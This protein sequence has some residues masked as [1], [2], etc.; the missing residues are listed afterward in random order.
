MKGAR[1]LALGLCLAVTLAASS[2]RAQGDPRLRWRTVESPH[3]S[4]HF[5]NDLEPVA[6]RVAEVAEGAYE[7][8][9]GPMGLSLSQRTQVV[10]WDTTDDANG[11]ATSIPFNTVNL[12]V[13][14]PDDLSVLNQYDDWVS[15]LVTHELTHIL[16][17]D[18]ISGVAAVVNAIIGKQWSPNQ[19]QPRFIL[20]GLAVYEES[21][22]SRG[23]RLRSSMWDMQL[24]ADAL[25][26]N[27]ATLDQ[28][29]S[30]ANRW[31]HGN[32]WYLYGSSLFQYVAARFGPEVIPFLTR[33]YGSMAAPWQI[34]RAIRR[35]TGHSWEEIYDDWR[36]SLRARYALQR[37]AIA[38][39]GVEE[40]RRVTFQGETVRAPRY[41]PDGTLLYESSDGQSQSMI[42]ALSPAELARPRPRPAELAWQGS[43]SGFAVLDADHLLVSDI[44]PHRD[45]YLFHDLHRWSLSRDGGALSRAGSE[46][47]SDGWRAQQ[48]DAHPDGDTVAFTVNHRGTTELAEMSLTERRPRTIVRSRRYEQV[49][50]PRYSPDGAWIAFSR[51]SDGRRDLWRYRRADGHLEALTRDRALDLSPVYSPDG[52][53]LLWS[54]DRTGVMNLYAM[55]LATGER[56]Q[57]T[58][59]VMGA[60]QPAVSPDGRSIA[61]VGYTP[62]GWDLYVMP[63][64]P[65]RWRAPEAPL[66]D[67]FD[68]DGDTPPPIAHDHHA[69]E[70]S[71]QRGP[72]RPLALRVHDYDPWSTLRPRGWLLEYGV[73]GF[74]PQLAVRVLGADVVGRHS[75]NVRAGAGLVRGDPLFDATYVYRG[76]RP[77][78]RVRAYRTVDAGS[79]YSVSGANT[80][81]VAERV[82][83]ESELSVGFPG[84]FDAHSVS[85]SYEAQWVRALG[86][87]PLYRQGINPNDPPPTVPFE[88][89]VNGVRLSWGYSR[90]QRYAYSISAQ[91][92]FSAFA[93]VRVLDPAF[94]SA[95]GG[96]DLSA[97]VAG[98]LPMPWGTDRRRHVLAAR[99]GGGIAMTDAGERGAFALG[100]FPNL[101]VESL[102]D[103]FRLGV[104]N[105]GVALRGYPPLARVGS[106]FQLL[107]VEYRFP[108]WQT[109][110]GASSLPFFIQR[111]SGD[112]FM[113]A[114]NAGF[115][116]WR[117]D[118]LAVGAG[119]EVLVDLVLGYILPFTLRVGYARGFMEGGT[120]QTYGLLSAPF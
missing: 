100:G 23:G 85:L 109:R 69:G 66:E 96:I 98:Y 82:G 18:N 119:L 114:G 12:F 79:G 44:A 73:D 22:H 62:Y 120:D 25:G 65:S 24:R 9:R 3:F 105:G 58:N 94:G 14:A 118:T 117:L 15:T 4:V 41:L 20:E 40:G 8:L 68:R 112:V 92:G 5:Y 106:Q 47:L 83:G 71:S 78:L 74:G 35:A 13:T 17:T 107:N 29:A 102:I 67:F 88:G 50:A 2:A 39:R 46:R 103:A 84:V 81:W 110:R 32:I 56:W 116:P 21:L 80:Q 51:W 30:G 26:D 49:Y 90:V 93:S 1:R 61:Y 10:L 28:L 52:R 75:W 60:F 34:N 86:G 36:E 70:G 64:D 38:S 113:D 99:L 63:F 45:I 104:T 77:T 19:V 42:R 33:E 57:V 27:I 55:E 59:A 37:R 53:Y 95:V 76:L 111:V 54:S 48:P 89:W 31:P 72:S 11:S 87:L 16:H 101:S 7:R 115:G 97:A 108:V 43:P 91:Q 6:R